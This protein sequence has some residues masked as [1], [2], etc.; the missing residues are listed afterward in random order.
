MDCEN[1]RTKLS[2]RKA[3]TWRMGMLR[4]RLQY[5]VIQW[6]SYGGVADCLNLLAPEFYI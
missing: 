4:I 2:T 5:S 3:N 6:G 1:L